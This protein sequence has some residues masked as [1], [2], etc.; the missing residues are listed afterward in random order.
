MATPTSVRPCRGIVGMA[1]ANGFLLPSS[2]GHKPKHDKK[3]PACSASAVCGALVG[4]RASPATCYWATFCR[5][6]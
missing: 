5:W 1:V 4:D 6:G 2:R 3:I